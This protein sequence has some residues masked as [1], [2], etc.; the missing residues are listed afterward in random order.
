MLVDMMCPNC[1]AKLQFDDSKEVGFCPYC[2]EKINR[3]FSHMQSGPDHPN[4]F[5]SY[6]SINP[7]VR[8]VT[9]IVSTGVK[10]TYANGQTMSFRL[11]QG[12]QT[13]ILKIG[14]KNYSRNI[15]VPSD[16]T[17]VRI[18]ASF[19]GRAQITIDQP[20]VYLSQA[21][22]ANTNIRAEGNTTSENV[23]VNATINNITASSQINSAK[24]TATRKSNKAF[25]LI[26]IAVIASI[27]MLMMG[28][29][30][31]NIGNPS[32]LANDVGELSKVNKCHSV[33]V[34]GMA[35]SDAIFALED[36]GFTNLRGE[37]FDEIENNDNWI[38][39]AQS[40]AP[41]SV[42]K[43]DAL[44][45]L[46]CTRF[47]DYVN[48]VYTGKNI[49]YIQKLADK[50]GF[51]IKYQDSSANEL[52][53]SSLNDEVKTDIIASSAC[54]YNDVAKTAIVTVAYTGDDQNVVLPVLSEGT[55]VKVP[56]A[57]VPTEAPTA[58]PTPTS[59]SIPTPTPLPKN[60]ITKITIE[61]E[62]D[63]E[64]HLGEPSY[65]GTAIVTRKYP[66]R[67]IETKVYFVSENPEVATITNLSEKANTDQLF[68]ITPVA[69]GE[70]YV[71]AKTSD[72]YIT[73]NRIKVTVKPKVMAE[74]ISMSEDEVELYVYDVHYL[75]AEIYPENT[76]NKTLT[77]SSS[78]PSVVTVT[79]TGT[80]KAKS[81]G[82]AVITAKTANG[83]TAE[84][85]VTVITDAPEEEYDDSYDYSYGG[86][87]YEDDYD[88]EYYDDS[89][90][91]YSTEYVWI[92]TSKSAYAYHSRKDC[93]NM[94]APVQVTKEY[95]ESIGRTPCS[96]CC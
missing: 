55:T 38:V 14:K 33:D 26:P 10:N 61:T 63:I 3:S 17:P 49:N 79:K 43:S 85:Y 65:K 21:S 27:M 37:P 53:L 30:F 19:N 91:D 32:V 69:V 5:I 2:G 70:T 24:T 22:N 54:Q 39:T 25:V 90:E 50:S 82:E 51:G 94:K 42:V 96:K 56:E 13:I 7:A 71:Y 84:C 83:L 76:A 29:L 72:G 75:S 52:D 15:V 44:I 62:G 28:P 40:A 1:R 45:Q 34:T 64:F 36:A 66:N 80:L 35:L 81:C 95:A 46:D 4:V 92:S 48:T 77:W 74:S 59:T 89:Y 12:P 78:D 20:P 9:R 18:Y 41:G 23:P 73:S 31:K 16:N 11:P 86:Y 6:S 68:E 67:Y 60:K 57:T 88:D 58:T 93:S 87:D 8:M 47:D